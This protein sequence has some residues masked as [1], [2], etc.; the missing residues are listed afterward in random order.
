MPMVLCRV[1]NTAKIKRKM[2]VSIIFPFPNKKISMRE[3]VLMEN[4]E[5]G[6]ILIRD[7]IFV[8]FNEIIPAVC[9]KRTDFSYRLFLFYSFM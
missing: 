9:R 5:L 8:C 1:K 6:H 2:F 3:F 7:D 4:L